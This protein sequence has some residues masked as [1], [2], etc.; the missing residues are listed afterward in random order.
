MQITSFKSAINNNPAQETK[1]NPIQFKSKPGSD[2]FASFTGGKKE[3][4]E[5][6]LTKFWNKIRCGTQTPDNYYSTRLTLAL[7]EVKEVIDQGYTQNGIDMANNILKAVK[8]HSKASTGLLATH[9]TIGNIYKKIGNLKK[10][11]ENYTRAFVIY[12]KIPDRSG[13]RETIRQ[14][15]DKLIEIANNSGKPE[16]ARKIKQQLS[17]TTRRG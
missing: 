2:S 4:L 17:K 11:F 6:P 14:T 9:I 1:Q 15:A 5:I 10:A 7:E 13:Y 3:I 12:K 8:T 16:L